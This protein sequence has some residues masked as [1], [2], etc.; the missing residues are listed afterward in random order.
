M[1]ELRLLHDSLLAATDDPARLAKTAV[2]VEG[3]PYTYAELVD[4]ALR[5]AAALR[6]RGLGRGDRVAIYMDNTWPCVVSI[7]ATLIAG[8]VFL[9]VN[10]QTK[11]DKLAFILDDS[12]AK[13]LLSDAHLAKEYGAALAQAQQRPATIV[14]GDAADGA[15]SFDAVVAAA[16][17]LAG[18]AATIPLDLAALI[19]TS[20]STGNPKGVMQTHQ[21]MTFAAGSLVEYIRLGASDRILCALPLAFDYGLYQLLMSVRLGATLVLERSFTFPA[22][23]FA[24]MRETRVTVFPGVPTVF[25]MLLAAHGRE[26]LLFPDVTRVTN[27]AAALP[28]D[29]AVRLREV[30]PNALIYKMYGLTECKRVS[31]LEPE[32]VDAKPGSVGKAI[33]GTEVY[34]LSAEGHDVPPGETGIL[35]VRG[36]H[37]M[38]G[39]WNRPDLTALMLKPGRLPGER[40]LCTQ[41]HFRMDAEG[42]LYFVGRTDDIIKTRGEKVSPVEVENMLHAIDGVREAAVVGVPDELL[43]QA[44]RA[45]VVLKPGATLTDRQI[46]AYC[47]SHLENFMVPRDIVL[48]ADLPRTTTGKVSKKLLLEQPPA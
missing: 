46:R 5:L 37:V 30:F 31:Y 12:G 48:C 25:A 38:L 22:Q 16:A 44:I 18:R 35:H 13:F 9:I 40:V 47:A 28:D 15:E 8:G 43:G 36:P 19:Y 24:R 23:V 27:T 26:P 41:D 4:H 20:G 3:R 6:A 33:P 45:F 32:L 39:Y 7:F 17:P 14:S 34:L 29:F 42:F 1:R 21:S 10:P 11:A 2:I